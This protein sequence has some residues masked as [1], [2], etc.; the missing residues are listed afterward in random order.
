M[1]I[2]YS[3]WSSS[4]IY[5]AGCAD[6]SCLDD[7]CIHYGRHQRL[8]RTVGGLYLRST[9][10]LRGGWKRVWCERRKS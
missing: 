5:C 2:S 6:H 3:G 1:S 8:R 9:E 7:H 10:C 4:S